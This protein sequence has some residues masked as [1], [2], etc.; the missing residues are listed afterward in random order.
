MLDLKVVVGTSYILLFNMSRNDHILCQYVLISAGILDDDPAGL[1][2]D[3]PVR[4]IL[5]K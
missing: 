5:T 2:D 3:N 4:W 1:L